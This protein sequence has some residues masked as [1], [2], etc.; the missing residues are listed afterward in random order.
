MT[1][2]IA[3]LSEIALTYDAVFC[4]LWGCLHNGRTAYPAAV[5]AL[6]S[7]RKGGGRV[8]LV[9]NAPRP[10]ADVIAGFARLGVPQSCYDQVVSSGDAAQAGML[11]GMVGHRV[12]HLGPEKD[13]GFFNDIPPDFPADV[14]IERVPLADAEGIVCTGLF[15]DLTE[16]PDDYRS[17]LL[18]AK[19]L[20]LPLLCANPDLV[21]D[22]GDRR[23]YCA[24]AIARL[25]EDMGG[26]AHYFGKPHPPIYDLARSR[27]AGLGI[28]DDRILC[29]GDGIGTDV[30]GGIAEG[31][32]TLFV[33]GG[34]TADLFGADVEAPD[35]TLLM[36]WLARQELSPTAAIGR[37][38]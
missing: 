5:A 35:P 37:L 17:T 29:I 6:E 11:R 3:S 22:M 8:V 36:E 2:L 20:G 31:L 32:D 23:I 7:F 28:A 30:A 15:D 34:L 16:T 26:T 25:Y 10:A 21:V 18:L 14:P 4:D 19:T 12:Y 38:R 24:G 27:I 1:R 9:T 13:L 33:S